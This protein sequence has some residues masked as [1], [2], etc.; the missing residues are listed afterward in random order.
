MK[1]KQEAKFYIFYKKAEEEKE[2]IF[3]N[4]FSLYYGVDV[5]S[6]ALGWRKG[7]DGNGRE[8]SLRLI[9]H[10]CR[11]ENIFKATLIPKQSKQSWT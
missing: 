7:W 3:P 10:F 8:S 9:F 4:S 11:V 1:E 6:G 2:N 5:K